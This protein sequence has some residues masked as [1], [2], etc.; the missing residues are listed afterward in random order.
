M[1][2]PIE[3]TMVIEGE[4][5]A[6][7][8]AYEISPDAAVWLPRSQIEITPHADPAQTVIRMPEWLARNNGLI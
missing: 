2:D 3:L 5:S 7:V 1:R 6:A 8:L 4:T